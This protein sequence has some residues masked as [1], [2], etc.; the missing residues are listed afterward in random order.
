MCELSVSIA[1]HFLTAAPEPLLVAPPPNLPCPDQQ[2]LEDATLRT[3]S[4]AQLDG[5][6]TLAATGL[7]KASETKRMCSSNGSQVQHRDSQPSSCTNGPSDWQIVR[8]AS[9]ATCSQE[10]TE[11]SADH[12]RKAPDFSL[13]EALTDE[14][15]RASTA[16]CLTDSQNEGE[17]IRQKAESNAA[18]PQDSNHY[19][20]PS[21]HHSLTGQVCNAIEL[22]QPDLASEDTDYSGKL[23]RESPKSRGLTGHQEGRDGSEAIGNDLVKDLRANG[24]CYQGLHPITV[25]TLSDANTNGHVHSKYLASGEGAEALARLLRR[26]VEELGF[27]GAIDIEVKGTKRHGL[28]PGVFEDVLC[29]E[30]ILD[31]GLLRLQ[32][33]SQDATLHQP[34]N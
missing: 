7:H 1:Q 20:Q 11:L 4:S 10:A 29:E 25:G 14:T 27:G 26:F 8:R 31:L 9:D 12:S 28:T 32:K 30:S 34:Q 2:L 22:Q 33:L 17:T 19:S 5:H 16:N 23:S 24:I 21:G 3:S 6:P 13:A 15:V 18:A